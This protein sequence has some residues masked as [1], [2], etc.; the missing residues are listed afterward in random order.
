MEKKVNRKDYINSLGSF[1]KVEKGMAER[2]FFLMYL[3]DK[4]YGKV[5]TVQEAQADMEAAGLGKPTLTRMRASLKK[6]RRA[7]KINDNQWRIKTAEIDEEVIAKYSVHLGS[8]H[9][10]FGGISTDKNLAM[11]S[12]H[13]KIERVSIA[14]FDAGLYKE[15][16]QNALV[17]VIHEVKVKT[18][19]P[20]DPQGKDLDGDKLMQHVFGCDNQ[21][22]LIKFNALSNSL[23]KA[24][25]R[26]LMNLFKGIVGI[27]DRKAHMNFIQKDPQKAFEYLVLASLLLRLVDEHTV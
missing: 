25:Q 13:P 23:D 21:L 6:D 18:G 9:N 22:P 14:A 16:I 1:G 20:K 5:Y 17:E 2:L 12:L 3:Y 11:Y 27:R 4:L 26:G 15:A 24:E 10:S 7:V 19:N 8:K